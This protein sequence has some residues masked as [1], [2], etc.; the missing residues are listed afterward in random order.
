MAGVLLAA[1]AALLAGGA[2]PSAPTAVALVAGS[3]LVQV[4]AQLVG[5]ACG[6]LVPRPALAM[7]ATIVV[8]MSVTVVLTAVAPGLVHWHTPYGNA[9]SLL[10]GE[11]DVA[12]LCLVALLWCA[13]PNAV[14]LT[15]SASRRS[16][17][18]W[19]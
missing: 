11:P 8:P 5:T 18:S 16:R 9:Q 19:G 12:A 7:A 4:I 17:S 15:R 13:I 3:V 14:G 10:A 2:W 6:L 1:L